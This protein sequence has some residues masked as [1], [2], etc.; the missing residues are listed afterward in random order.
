MVF[1][2][3]CIGNNVLALIG[4]ATVLTSFHLA[5]LEEYYIGT[6]ALPVCNGVSDGSWLLILLF[7]LS[8][9]CGKAIWTPKIVEDIN[10]LGMGSLNVG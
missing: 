5:T 9:I 3:I 6:L 2:C 10:F 4:Y 8:G 7:I 1:R